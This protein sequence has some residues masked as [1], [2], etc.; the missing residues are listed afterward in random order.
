[1]LRPLRAAAG[2]LVAASLLICGVAACSLV[3]PF[4][5]AKEA[6]RHIQKD[7]DSTQFRD[8]AR[9]EGEGVRGEYNSKNSYGAYVGF[10]PFQYVDSAV[11]T[12]DSDLENG[13]WEK[14]TRKCWGKFYSSSNT[15]SSVADD[16]GG[17]LP[18]IDDL[19]AP[20]VATAPTDTVAAD[21]VDDN[22]EIG[23]DNWQ[24]D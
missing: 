9:C 6:V 12:I 15:I 22:A 11:T 3:D 14:A 20:K 19:A 21:E 17:N 8:V 16:I 4:A 5:E 1:M 18:A 7:P 24:G 13:L 23:R 10:K 2:R